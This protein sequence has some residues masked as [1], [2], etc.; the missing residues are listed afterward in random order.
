[1]QF[2]TS[3]TGGSSRR[4]GSL[5]GGTADTATFAGEAVSDERLS[6]SERELDG[7]RRLAGFAGD[8]SA[9]P[10]SLEWPEDAAF[11]AAREHQ[12]LSDEF[13]ELTSALLGA[14]YPHYL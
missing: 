12:R 4:C 2:K 14:L 8:A 5:F 13:P 9:V 7:L 1:M 6:N 3:Q 10:L 11:V